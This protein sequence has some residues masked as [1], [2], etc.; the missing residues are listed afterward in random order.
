[1]DDNLIMFQVVN[2][3]LAKLGILYERHKLPLYTYFYRVTAGDQN[4]SEDLVHQVFVRILSYKHSFK[5]TGAFQH[6]LFHIAHHVAIDYSK[7][8]KVHL[9]ATTI[10]DRSDPD[11][12]AQDKLETKEKVTLLDRALQQL[13]E[14]D[15]Q[16]L[17]LAKIKGLRYA[18]IAEMLETTEGAIRVR[19]HRAMAELKAIYQKIEKV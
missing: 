6:W 11:S 5:G 1:M 3:D 13:R 12:N 14:E 18:D 19:V 9:D 15:R 7:A 16:L 4:F 2:G 10:T 17:S 8:R